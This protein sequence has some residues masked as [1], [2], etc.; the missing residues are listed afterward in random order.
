M[1]CQV[2]PF[3]DRLHLTFTLYLFQVTYVVATVNKISKNHVGCLMYNT[4]NV[5]IIKPPEVP[6]NQWPGR[7]VEVDDTITFKV[8]KVDVSEVIP[9]VIGEFPP[10]M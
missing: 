2:R 6:Y 9:Y 3:P 7:H 10:D 4:F 8:V 5:S 1:Y